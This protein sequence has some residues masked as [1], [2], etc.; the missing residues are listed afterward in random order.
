MEQRRCNV[1]VIRTPFEALGVQPFSPLETSSSPTATGGPRRTTGAVDSKFPVGARGVRQ[2]AAAQRETASSPPNNG[3]TPQRL[4]PTALGPGS[5]DTLPLLLRCRKGQLLAWDAVTHELIS[6]CSHGADTSVVQCICTPQNVFSRVECAA[7]KEALEEDR[8]V[9]LWDPNTLERRGVL[10]SHAGRVT[11]MAVSSTQPDTV[12]TAGQDHTIH[13]WDLAVSAKAPQIRINTSAQGHVEALAICGD[14]LVAG[15]SDV[16]L[17]VWELATGTALTRT[18]ADIPSSVTT[19]MVAPALL[20]SSPLRGSGSRRGTSTTTAADSA[21]GLRVFAGHSDGYVREWRIRLSTSAGSPTSPSFSSTSVLPWVSERVWQHKAHRALVSTIVTDSDVLVS[22]SSLDGTCAYHLVSG[23][24]C[25]VS[26]DGGAAVALDAANKRLLLGT[27]T[28][29]LLLYSYAEFAAGSARGLLPVWSYRPHTS[30]VTGLLLQWTTGNVCKRVV[31]CSVDGSVVVLHYAEHPDGTTSPSV[32]VALAAAPAKADQ[33]LLGDTTVT[34]AMAF[35]TGAADGDSKDVSAYKGSP[36]VLYRPQAANGHGAMCPGPSLPSSATTVTALAWDGSLRSWLVATEDGYV[37]VLA[38]DASTAL[39]SGGSSDSGTVLRHQWSVAPYRVTHFSC[40]AVVTA[41]PD[42]ESA[43]RAT[44]VSMCLVKE[45]K[46]DEDRLGLIAVQPLCDDL[47]DSNIPVKLP[48]GWHLSTMWP[49]ST[50]LVPHP[51]RASVTKG[52][53]S[54]FTMVVQCMNGVVQLFT[55]SPPTSSTGSPLSSLWSLRKGPALCTSTPSWP[56]HGKGGGV[57]RN[58]HTSSASLLPLHQQQQSHRGSQ[59]ARPASLV[60]ALV[61]PSET[62][63]TC[64]RG[65]TVVFTA[66]EVT[67]KRCWCPHGEGEVQSIPFGEEGQGTRPTK[68]IGPAAS[69][70]HRVATPHRL[71]AVYTV[72]QGSTLLAVSRESSSDVELLDHSGSPL[73]RV[74]HSG[75]VVPLQEVFGR[76]KP[77][78][79]FPD[80]VGAEAASSTVSTSPS[81]VTSDAAT[82][83]PFCTAIGACAAGRYVAMGYADGLVQLA[84]ASQPTVFARF[85]QPEPVQ[86]LWALEDRVV[87]ATPTGQLRVHRLYRRTLLDRSNSLPS[88][89]PS[90]AI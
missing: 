44:V 80:G 38:D 21:T 84:E 74:R 30:A 71:A 15:G 35:A 1:E 52:A 24:H 16:A 61:L 85:W 26:D 60:T 39:S 73:C 55:A 58:G 63:P 41:A 67:L 12:V 47:Q 49:V 18:E 79:S 46:N 19:L 57:G 48:R 36:V 83:A 64:S 3:T 2:L 59:K 88:S 43:P 33:P 86:Q 82:A 70:A 45:D 6:S 7:G 8:A 11:A 51:P 78:L 31:S 65:F 69:S 20:P 56:L 10:R 89:L 68:A 4:T 32:T 72:D 76:R 50:T 22:C 54:P 90:R 28:G 81:V 62:D 14:Y 34:T 77:S 5:S 42:A 53:P 87:T 29:A 9:F 25:R 75:D 23:T 17:T 66:D 13:I 40:A 27:D 37:R